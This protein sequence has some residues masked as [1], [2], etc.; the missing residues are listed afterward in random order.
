[1]KEYE[2]IASYF[3]RVDDTVNAIKGLGEDMEEHVVIQKVLRS[4]PMRFDLKIST[5]EERG[6]L[7]KLTMDEPYGILI[8]Y[9]MRTEKDNQ[10]MKE[11]T[12]KA[13]KKIKKK[14]KKKAKSNCSYNND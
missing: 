11:A 10:I 7:D 9:E 12:F 3:L 6:Y 8:T 4:L 5:L 13:S 14:Y 1:M 2:N